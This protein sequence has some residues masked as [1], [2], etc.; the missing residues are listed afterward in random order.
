MTI[1]EEPLVA[2]AYMALL[3]NFQIRPKMDT[4]VPSVGQ[5]KNGETFTVFQVFPEVNGIVWGRISSN[6]NGLPSRFV[7]LRVNNHPKAQ[8]V[9]RFADE[10]QNNLIAALRDL[11]AEI[12]ELVY[13]FRSKS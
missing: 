10:D 4:T 13:A 6:T 2:G 11:A 3:D 12:H 7:G 1:I 9:E 5:F 8:L